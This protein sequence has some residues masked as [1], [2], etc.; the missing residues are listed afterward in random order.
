M[1]DN[2]FWKENEGMFVK[3]DDKNYYV[4]GGFDKENKFTFEINKG[5]GNFIIF[6]KDNNRDDFIILLEKLANYPI[7]RFIFNTIIDTLDDMG[8]KHSMTRR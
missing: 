2:I 3:I 6:N 7:N 4:Y 1:I 5:H 8:I